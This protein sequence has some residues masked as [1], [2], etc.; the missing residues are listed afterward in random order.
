[1][2][3][4]CTFSKN[5]RANLKNLGARR[6][7]STKFHTKNPHISYA[8]QT[9]ICKSLEYGCHLSKSGCV[10]FISGDTMQTVSQRVLRLHRWKSRILL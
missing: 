9:G 8:W 4:V 1:M 10:V 7:T 3:E 5:S 6:V 2:A